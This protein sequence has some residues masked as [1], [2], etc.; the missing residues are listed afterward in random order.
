RLALGFGTRRDV[1]RARHDHSENHRRRDQGGEGKGAF[2]VL[3]HTDVLLLVQVPWRDNGRTPGGAPA[4][5]DL[6]RI[7]RRRCSTRM[8]RFIA[9]PAPACSSR[10]AAAASSTPSCMKRKGTP[11]AIASSAIA[12]TCSER[13]KTSTTSIRTSGGTSES[14]RYERSPR[15]SRY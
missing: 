3:F 13:R 14:D 5:L 4:F 9:P 15:I 12:A 8:Q 6:G 11:R 10:R 1:H 7:P 2:R